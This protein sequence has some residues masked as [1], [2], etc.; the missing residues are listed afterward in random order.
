MQQ[1]TIRKTVVFNKISLVCGVISTVLCL[2][3]RIVSGSPFDMIH[4]LGNSEFIPPIWI[5]N[6][7]C[8][9]WSFISGYAGGMI[10]NEVACRRICGREEICAYRGGLFFISQLYL[11][12]TWYPL[13]F[14][15]ESIFLSLL[16]ALLAV[17]CSGICSASWSRASKISALIMAAYTIWLTY[18]LLINFSIFV[19]N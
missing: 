2:A 17:I 5:F 11:A 15:S 18:V 19:H 16:T 13:F 4:K 10:I 8:M 6:L 3:V 9:T 7:L 14:A 12:L 1:K